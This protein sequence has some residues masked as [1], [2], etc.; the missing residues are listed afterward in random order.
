MKHIPEMKRLPKIATLL[1]GAAI[2]HTHTASASPDAATDPRIDPQIR[3]F[4]AELDKD[5]SPFWELPQPK[6]QDIL[7]ALQNKTPVDMSGVTTV[8]KTI[9]QDG[10]TVKI[11]IMKPDHVTGT[12][13]VLF[14]IHG[15][16]WIVGNFQNHQR[17]LRDLVVG[18]GQI[19]VFVEYTPLPA[20]K[21]P[22]QLDEC[23]AALQ[24]TAEHA[25]EFGGDGSRIAV[26]GN[27]VGGNMSAAL[28]LMTKDRQGPRI[29]YQVLFI[30]ATDAS[31]DT[32]SYHQFATGRFLSRD[33][34]KYGWDLYAPRAKTRDNPYVSPLRASDEELEGLPPALVIT[35]E[36]DPLRD[37]GDAYARKLKNAG[38]EVTAVRYNGVI[39]DFVLLNAIRHVPEVEAA[40]RQASEGIRDH[41]NAISVDP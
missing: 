23:Y 10:K 12:P 21:F 39:H 37:E 36:N 25:G 22:T 33:F 8:E 3:P 27:S 7:T 11:Y 35:A 17:L 6:P 19:G 32:G 34:M 5:P 26:A 24:W 31:V 2:M 15:G 29:S 18:S 4:L 16:V 14:F 28:T 1:I 41:L 38:V 20:A 30:P 9:T 13:G 40:I